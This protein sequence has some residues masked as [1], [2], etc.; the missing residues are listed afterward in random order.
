MEY[1]MKKIVYALLLLAFISGCSFFK[2]PSYS[3]TY[4]LPVTYDAY[5]TDPF[6]YFSK[7][8]STLF[9]EAYYV[10]V[11]GF[12]SKM[13]GEG[14][15]KTFAGGCMYSMGRDTVLTGFHS[16]STYKV[17]CHYGAAQKSLAYMVFYQSANMPESPMTVTLANDQCYCKPVVVYVNNTN[18]VVNAVRNGTMLNGGPFKEGDWAKLTIKGSLK[19]SACGEV[20]INLADYKAFRD[21]V[22]TEWTP[23]DLKDISNCDKL[24]F[25]ITSSRSDFP[26]YACFDTWYFSSHVE[27]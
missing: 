7:P 8:D 9:T 1:D 13:V 3:S 26:K 16:P 23:V 4:E 21:S 10:D 14:D 17:H 2:G 22:I 18:L 25:E 19:G 5:G 27:Y 12:M 20:S 24:N 15:K 6:D 11:V